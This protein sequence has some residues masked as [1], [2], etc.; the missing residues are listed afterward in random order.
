VGEC[1]LCGQPGQLVDDPVLG[2][3]IPLGEPSIWP[4][5]SMGMA[6]LP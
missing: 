6:S 4:F 5:W 3:D 1:L 2:A